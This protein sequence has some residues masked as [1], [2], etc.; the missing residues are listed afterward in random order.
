M[1]LRR[2]KKLG[3]GVV[4]DLSL[5]ARGLKLKKIR[6]L[7]RGGVKSDE[8][9]GDGGGVFNSSPGDI[10]MILASLTHFDVFSCEIYK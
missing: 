10:L 2:K 9:R 6:R 8:A 5:G 7:M 1:G 3:V 4:M